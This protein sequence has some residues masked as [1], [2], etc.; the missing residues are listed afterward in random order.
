MSAAVLRFTGSFVCICVLLYTAHRTSNLY[1]I[2]AS[3]SVDNVNDLEFNPLYDT[4]FQIK[5]KSPLP[6]PLLK[7]S[8]ALYIKVFSY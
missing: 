6:S 3:E 4:N 1:I 7:T 2:T 5:T 8:P